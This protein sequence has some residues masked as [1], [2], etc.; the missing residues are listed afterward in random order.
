MYY[1]NKKR[2]KAYNMLKM[3]NIQNIS[4][5]LNEIGYLKETKI[6]QALQFYKQIITDGFLISNILKNQNNKTS[7]NQN[8]H[9]QNNKQ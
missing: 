2:W 7:C 3:T 4:T 5:S 6:T 1:T 9:F 8:T